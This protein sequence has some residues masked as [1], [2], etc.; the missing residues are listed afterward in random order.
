MNQNLWNSVAVSKSLYAAI[1][2]VTGDQGKIE[3]RDWKLEDYP[4]KQQCF[5]MPK[6]IRAVL[7]FS[8][9][10]DSLAVADPPQARIWDQLLQVRL[11]PKHRTGQLNWGRRLPFVSV[12]FKVKFSKRGP[13]EPSF[14]SRGFIFTLLCGIAASL[15]QRHEGLYA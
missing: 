2:F 4:P 1:Q 3:F 8:D 14:R 15:E 10:L 11:G 7:P 6:D 9:G 13:S 12:P 5:E